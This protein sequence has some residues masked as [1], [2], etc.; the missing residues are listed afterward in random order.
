MKEISSDFAKIVEKYFIT[1]KFSEIS[2]YLD[3]ICNLIYNL[4]CMN[5][6]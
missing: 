3:K 2:K 4:I 5:I 1:K 6:F